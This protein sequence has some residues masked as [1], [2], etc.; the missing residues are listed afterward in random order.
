[1]HTFLFVLAILSAA[2]VVFAISKAQHP[3]KT[4]TR[5]VAGGIGAL[6]F[7]NITSV[8]TGCY[9]AVNLFTAFAVTFLSL[10]GVI[11][12]VVLNLVFV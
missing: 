9:I 2:A 5:S 7:V 11:G 3:L 10:P 4:A 1:M 8:A 12:L 6:L